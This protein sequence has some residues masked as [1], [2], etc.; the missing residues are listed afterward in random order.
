[1]R[2]SCSGTAPAVVAGDAA[3]RAGVATTPRPAS[4]GR[5]S[6]FAGS[7]SGSGST[8]IAAHQHNRQARLIELDP[9]YCDVIC[10]RYQELTGDKPIAEATGNPHDFTEEVDAAT[11]GRSTEAS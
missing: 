4:S 2:S 1:M 6:P 3:A 8:L 11:D 5:G 9:R 7:G 10:R